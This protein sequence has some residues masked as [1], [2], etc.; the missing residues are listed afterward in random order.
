MLGAPA[1]AGRAALRGGAGLVTLAVPASVQIAVASLCPCATSIP[2]PETNDGRIDPEPATRTF[3]ESGLLGGEP[4]ATRPNV[5][6]VGPGLGTG[7]RTCGQTVWSMINAFRRDAKIPAVIDADALNLLVKGDGASPA[8]WDARPH[9]STVITPHPG[10]LARM[11]GV[12]PNDIQK[13]R[14]GFAVGTA[15]LMNPQDPAPADRAVVVL[16]GAGTIVTDGRR[17]YVNDTGNPGMATGGSGDVLAGL[18]GALIGQGM[19]RFDAAV[20]GVYLHGRAGDL[21]AAH[22][23]QTSLIAT[24]LIDALPRAFAEMGHRPA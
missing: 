7:P 20:A 13:D 4:R 23:G 11:Y 22:R 2:L 6:V 19:T 15:E 16:K 8:G 9:P 18:I 3:E 24:D 10:E 17:L 21:A 5:I 1:L 12:G 14:E